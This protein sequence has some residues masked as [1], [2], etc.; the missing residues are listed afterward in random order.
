M[1][2]AD[3]NTIRRGPHRAT[4]HMTKFTLFN[5]AGKPV[6][7][8]SVEAAEL[9]H[10]KATQQSEAQISHHIAIIDRSGSMWGDITALKQ[11]LEKQFTLD[12]YQRSQL[13]ISLISY[14]SNG[15]CK[16]HFEHA[17]VT[18][19]MQTNSP[20]LQALRVISAG[21]CTGMSQAMKMAVGLVRKDEL[22]GITLHSDGWANDPSPYSEQQAMESI[23]KEV[24]ATSAF[25]N[26]VAYRESSDFGFLSKVA[27]L[28]SGRC[29]L[30][31]N[32]KE[33]YDAIYDTSAVLNRA[34]V[35]VTVYQPNGADMVVFTS[36]T[37]KRINGASGELKVAG[38]TKEDTG[39]VYRYHSVTESEYNTDKDSADQT[40]DAV[41]AFAA[42]NLALG[43]LNTAKYALVSTQNQDLAET[44]AKALT[45][46]QIAALAT[47]LQAVL[48]GDSKKP[49]TDGRPLNFSGRTSVLKVL[50]VLDEHR[51][52]IEINLTDLQKVY[53]RRGVKR[54]RGVRDDSG[55]LVTPE[56]DTEL[57]DQR[58]W[59]KLGTFDINRGSATVNM[60]IARPCKLIKVADRSV[61]A[62][63]AGV[64]IDKLSEFNAYTLIGDGELN[65]PALHLSIKD[66]PA[67]TALNQLNCC[68][69][70]NDGDHGFETT[71]NLEALPVIDYGFD[72]DLSQLGATYN[73]IVEASVL[74]K[75]L[76]AVA[77]EESDSLTPEQV[78]ALK[79]HCLSKNL[80]L[81][82]P[83]TTEYTDLA[84]ALN[85]GTIDI[86]VA[87]KVVVGNSKLLGASLPSANAFLDRWYEQIE[88]GSG[89]VADKATFAAFLDRGTTYRG[90][91]L[92]ARAKPA[93]TDG[94]CKPVFD[95]FLGLKSNGSV[96]RILTAAG[97][98]DT[99][100]TLLKDG[101]A[102]VLRAKK[103]VDDY[104]EDL[105]QESIIPLV[106]FVASTGLLPDSVN[107]TAMTADQIAAKYPDLKL[108]KDEKEGTFFE[109]KAGVILAAFPEKACFSTG[110]QPVVNVAQ[111]VQSPAKSPTPPATKPA[112]AKK[113]SALSRV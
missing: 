6:S 108:G 112:K 16:L 46:T 47:D 55:N 88:K 102:G 84:Q 5:F 44:H 64:K 12:E 71:I 107:A 111:Q 81:N 80:Y 38:L 50:Q 113:R 100:A 37:A 63:V 56:F 68:S 99:L 39:V 15:D 62:E 85:D 61:V 29:T 9:N 21:G 72:K 105:Y 94:I 103:L 23:C 25:V 33:V 26:T 1:T 32:I 73:Q 7:H 35:P 24:S 87:Y 49:A 78:E 90:K 18:K 70:N 96:N 34:A 36:K 53:Q 82:F 95:D 20:M 106:F 27:N 42:A 74:A 3:N 43:R 110:R 19:I 11:T 77:K 48:F 66:G 8:W 40:H 86:R 67:I 60:T 4:T 109:L 52:D 17:P 89:T 83:T 93:V 2:M 14:A 91:S 92:S 51:D 13:H 41:Y 76:S 54:V 104:I 69:M 79:K 22:T 28:G 30:A 97:S 59:V 10:A 57:N 75:I 45:N 101:A 65:V 31:R 58:E 98:N